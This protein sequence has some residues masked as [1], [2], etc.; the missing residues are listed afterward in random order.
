[1]AVLVCP[2][3]RAAGGRVA[4][5]DASGSYRTGGWAWARTDYAG[6]VNLFPSRVGLKTFPRCLTFDDIPDGTGTTILL[7]E[8]AF[9]AENWKTGSWYW[10][11][12]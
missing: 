2:S 10:D 9:N 4:Q 5:D 1:M 11:E 3:R 6:N 12:P 7:G 8:K